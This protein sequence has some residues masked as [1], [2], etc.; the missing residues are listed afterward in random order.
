MNIIKGALNSWTESVEKANFYIGD[1]NMPYEID[2]IS[3]LLPN[4]LSAVEFATSAVMEEGVTLFNRAA[5]HVHTWPLRSHYDVDYL[6][7]TLPEPMQDVRLEVMSLGE[8]FSP[9]HYT[10]LN[11]TGGEKVVIHLSFKCE[12]PEAY[13]DAV[14]IMSSDAHLIQACKSE[15]GLFSYFETTAMEGTQIYLKPRVNLREFLQKDKRESAE[16]L[17]VKERG[18]FGMPTVGQ[19]AVGDIDREFKGRAIKDNPQA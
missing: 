18:D 1:L 16:R 9:L 8:G 15:Y 19:F 3:L 4:Y 6:F 12:D 13:A 11:S 5:D 17:D 14:D 7:L 2:E 10:A